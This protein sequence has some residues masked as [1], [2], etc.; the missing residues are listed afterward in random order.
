M[1]AV[2]QK[3]IVHVF[4]LILLVAGIALGI[5]GL[6]QALLQLPFGLLSDRFGRKRIIT[7]AKSGCCW[8]QTT[9]YAVVPKRGLVATKIFTEDAS[10]PDGRYVY[11][12]TETRSS[13]AQK[14]MSSKTRK[15]KISDYY[16][17]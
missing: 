16:P 8:H 10:S 12:T 7:F 4:M 11:V 14:H 2:N 17:Q 6:T 3:G 1:S 5:Y 15:Y 13:I 9:E